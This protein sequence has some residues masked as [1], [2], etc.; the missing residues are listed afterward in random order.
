MK[1]TKEINEIKK[2]E[3]RIIHLLK[4]LKRFEKEE[5][6]MWWEELSNY[7]RDDIIFHLYKNQEKI[8]PLP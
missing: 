5:C 7:T 6:E 4:A 1:V 3:Y 8:K 2:Q